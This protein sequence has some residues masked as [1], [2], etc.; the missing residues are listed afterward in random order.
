MVVYY[1]LVILEV[2]NFRSLQLKSYMKLASFG[3]WWELL[4]FV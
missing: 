1:I 2:H 4:H 3:I